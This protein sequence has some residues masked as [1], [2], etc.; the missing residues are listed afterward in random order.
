MTSPYYYYLDIISKWPTAFVTQNQFFM[1]FDLESVGALRA[2]LASTVRRIDSGSDNTWDI[3]KEVVDTLIKKENQLTTE[4][5]IGCVFAR[6]IR[7]PGETVT[8][9]ND[10]LDYSGYQAPATTSGRQSYKK[11]QI[12]FAETNSSF[13]DLVIRPWI[14]L[15]G[16]YG[17][18]ARNNPRNNPKS[19]K[20]SS[21]NAVYLGKAGA[22]NPSI[23]RKIVTF[24]NVAPVSVGGLT[25]SYAT[26]GMQYTSVEFTY[27]SYSVLAPDYIIE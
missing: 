15:V 19:V 18:I 22:Y 14:V 3:P 10:G 5:L 9:G 6:E 13:I 4:N 7:L 21:L 24:N 1:W 12:V 8:A 23:Q 11:V 27:D 25:N 16:Y 20:C 26:D 2:D 17:F